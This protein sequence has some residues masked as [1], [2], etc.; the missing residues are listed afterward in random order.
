MR[1]WIL[2]GVALTFA[3]PAWA[4]DSDQEAA[5]AIVVTGNPLSETAKR[6]KACL[7]RHCPPTEDIDASLAHAENQFLEGDYKAARATLASS[8]DR[9]AKYAKQY[10][11]EVADLDRAYGRITGMD[12]YPE[13]GRILQ[14]G[15]LDTLKGGLAEGDTRILKQR[16]MTGDEYVQT[17]RLQAAIDVYRKVEKQA[18]KLNAMRIVG[19]AMLR[20]A[21]LYASLGT[22]NPNFRDAARIEL[23]RIDRTTEPELAGIRTAAQVLRA[24]LAGAAGD[25]AEM[26]AAIARLGHNGF[27]SPVLVYDK[28]PFADVQPSTGVINRTLDTNPEWIDIRYRIDASGH[29]QDV[30]QLR[31]STQVTYDWPQYIL[32]SIARRRYVPLKLPEGS[33]GLVRIERFT[34]VF[35]AESHTG[36]NMRSRSTKPRLVSLDLTP[37][38]PAAPKGR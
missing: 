29:V 13:W 24:R 20:P 37:D 11:V 31:T 2:A 34:L 30:D 26:E 28:P 17:G 32:K 35:D 8:H 10:P 4:Q 12:G 21:M 23:K 19:V 27:S 33:N 14:I 5:P 1:S 7:D 3:M 18:R 6:L 36:S 25:E 16:L 38:P 9:N 15:A 22:N